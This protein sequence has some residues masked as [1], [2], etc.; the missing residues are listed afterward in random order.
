MKVIITTLNF[1]SFNKILSIL[2]KLKVVFNLIVKT[3]NTDENAD[4]LR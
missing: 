2:N 3:F 4:E 1:F